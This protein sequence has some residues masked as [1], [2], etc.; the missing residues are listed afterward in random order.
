MEIVTVA[1]LT[2]LVLKLV[3]VAKQLT[4]GATRPAITQAIAWAIGTAVAVLA[5][6][7]DITAGMSLAEGMPP[8]GAM[9]LASLT[10]VGFSLGSAGGVVVDF[11]K[12]VDNTDSAAVPPLGGGAIDREA[13]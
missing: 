2:A 1:G 10:L 5:A 9:D 4:A 8:L 12:A 11:K 7:A 3:D 6:E 13:A